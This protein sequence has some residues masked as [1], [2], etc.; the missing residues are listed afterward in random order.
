[1]SLMTLFGPH[2]TLWIRAQ[3]YEKSE[4]VEWFS[5]YFEHTSVRGP[6]TDVS[7]VYRRTSGAILPY[8]VGDFQS[9]WQPDI[10]EITAGKCVLP[11][12]V[13]SA[14][15]DRSFADAPVYDVHMWGG[16]FLISSSGRLFVF[17]ANAS[18]T[19]F[20]GTRRRRD[21]RFSACVRQPRKSDFAAVPIASSF[22]HP[23]CPG[24]L[25]I[26]VVYRPY[27]TSTLPTYAPPRTHVHKPPT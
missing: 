27:T 19:A 10:G 13:V 16:G 25:A 18:G 20:D 6:V 14:H 15:D 7:R 2:D 26:D 23:L 4:P 9:P 5:C 24:V 22:F 17:T 1:M 21:D 8:P 11:R 3:S 12:A